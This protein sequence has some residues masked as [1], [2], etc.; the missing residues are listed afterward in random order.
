MFAFAQ[1]G[2]HQERDRLLLPLAP[3][4]DHELWRACR[5]ECLDTRLLLRGFESPPHLE[6]DSVNVAPVHYLSHK[7]RR[8]L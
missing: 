7:R 8:P 4:A 1:S 2:I 5:T 3:N 6:E